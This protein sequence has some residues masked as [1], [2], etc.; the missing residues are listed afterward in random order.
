MTSALTR[1]FIRYV[2]GTLLGTG[3]SMAILADPDLVKLIDESLTLILSI[4][5]PIVFAGF[6]AVEAWWRRDIKRGKP[7]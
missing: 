1:V 6:G 4:L 5:T 3:L 7:V 2:L